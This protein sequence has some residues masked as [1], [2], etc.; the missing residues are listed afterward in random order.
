MA[1]VSYIDLKSKRTEAVAPRSLFGT[2]FEINEGESNI[3]ED[4]IQKVNKRKE[5]VDKTAA[6]RSPSSEDKL[7]IM[8]EAIERQDLK[9][10]FAEGRLKNRQTDALRFSSTAAEVE[11]ESN[12]PKGTFSPYR[13]DV[14]HQSGDIAYAAEFN[15][16]GLDSRYDYN[17]ERCRPRIKQGSYKQAGNVLTTGNLFT[18]KGKS[19]S[20]SISD[21]GRL[22]LHRG[23]SSSSAR[24][25]AS[26][27]SIP[28]N[29]KHTYGEELC[30]KV[31]LEIM[32]EKSSL[33]LDGNSTLSSSKSSPAPE[34]DPM[35]DA[36]GN[37]LRQD[38]FNG[39]PHNKVNSLNMDSYTQDIHNKSKNEFPPMFAVQKN[40]DSRWAED[41]VIRGR[42]LKAWDQ[43]MIEKQSK[44]TK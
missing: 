6:F 14:K 1:A 35:Y 19:N 41:C 10:R 33:T 24:S 27:N 39:V 20:S 3:N 42:V 34:R 7:R 2:A 23:I 36:L 25:Y 8:K 40:M 28:P 15:H 4:E 12:K 30:S 5:K 31:K 32:A 38:I 11:P 29:I 16:L 26:S 21:T 9:V 44:K 17:Y 13:A 18:Y 37:A 43:M 22:Q